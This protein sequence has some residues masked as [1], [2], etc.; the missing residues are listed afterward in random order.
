[1]GWKVQ[2]N[3]KDCYKNNKDFLYNGI[4]THF[5]SSTYFSSHLEQLILD[6]N[7]KSLKLE[8]INNFKIYE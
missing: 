6:Y 3:Y 2:V 7:F 5:Y 1:M 4:E 8:T